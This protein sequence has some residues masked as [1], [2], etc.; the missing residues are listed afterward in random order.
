MRF[1]SCELRPRFFTLFYFTVFFTDFLTILFFY[2]FPF[3]QTYS[4]LE[5]SKIDFTKT[6]W[7]DAQM[8][9]SGLDSDI[10][11]I[12]LDPSTGSLLS[13]GTFS[14]LAGCFYYTSSVLAQY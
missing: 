6:V 12:T 1:F 14:T 5:G 4:F 3:F 7:R 10:K 13:A 8:S 2:P 11:L 9:I